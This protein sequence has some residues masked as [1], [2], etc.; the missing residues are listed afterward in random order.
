[1]WLR[2][3]TWPRRRDPPGQLPLR[4]RGTRADGGGVR[5]DAGAGGGDRGGDGAARGRGARG[6]AERQLLRRRHGDD[7]E[8]LDLPIGRPSEAPPRNR[9]A[10]PA[11][12]PRA[13]ARLPSGPATPCG[14]H[15]TPK[16]NCL[17]THSIGV[18]R[19]RLIGGLAR[20]STNLRALHSIPSAR[21]STIWAEV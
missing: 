5:D 15:S 11:R 7:A 2:P 6:A 8:S 19:R 18:R 3:P 21:C 12:S 4:G 20:R 9:A 16:M 1:A 13:A 10:A 14:Y 17:A